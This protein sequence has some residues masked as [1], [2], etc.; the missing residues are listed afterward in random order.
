MVFWGAHELDVLDEHAEVSHAW[1]LM[2]V[3]KSTVDGVKMGMNIID[4]LHVE[5]VD[6]WKIAVG[7]F[8]YRQSALV[9][10]IGGIAQSGSAFEVAF[11]GRMECW[12]VEEG[13]QS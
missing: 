4:M 13:T 3:D 1:Y 12:A 6:V 11:Q 7:V 9:V 8:H 5:V 2:G 10:E